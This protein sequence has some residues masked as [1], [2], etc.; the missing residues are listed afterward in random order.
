MPTATVRFGVSPSKST[1]R[2]TAKSGDAPTTGLDRATPILETATKFNSRPP[3]K[4]AS[5]ARNRRA[6]L[7]PL[8]RERLGA[9]HRHHEN[10]RANHAN[11][12]RDDDA[13]RWPHVLDAE[14]GKEGRG[15]ESHRSG[16]GEQDA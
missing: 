5:P 14:P 12:Q 9:V 13:G 3:T 7:G 11:D 8:K 1:A 6:K 16:Q 2:A 10:R 15:P 4:L